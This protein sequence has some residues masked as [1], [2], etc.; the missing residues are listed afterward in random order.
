VLLQAARGLLETLYKP[1]Y[2]Y[3]RCGVMALDV[4]EEAWGQGD[5]FAPFPSARQAR[6]MA[7]VDGVNGK[8]G[9]A[10]IRFGSQGT[11]QAWAMRSAFKTPRY[12]TC[13]DEVLRVQ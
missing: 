5:L 10:T 3:Q 7:V 13:W 4:V 6:L 2:A 12:T 1:G 11:Q 8:M 9:S